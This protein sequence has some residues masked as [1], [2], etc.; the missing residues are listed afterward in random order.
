MRVRKLVIV[1]LVVLALAVGAAL[2]LRALLD[3]QMLARTIESQAAAWLER[4]VHIG[5]ARA[6][7][8]PTPRI[9]LTTVAVDGPPALVADEVIVGAGLKALFQRRVEDAVVRV[10]NGTITLDASAPTRPSPAS[11]ASGPSTPTT[12]SDAAGSRGGG[13]TIASVGEIRFENVAVRGGGRTLLLDFEGSL[14][15]DALDVRRLS[16]SSGETSIE[17]K[18]TVTSLQKLDGTFDLT[19][20][21]VDVDDVLALL[22]ALAPQSPSS[23]RA[24]TPGAGDTKG[25]GF[26]HILARAS[27]DKARALGYQIDHLTTSIDLHGTTL[28]ANPL[29]FELYGGRYDSKLALDLAAHRT[30]LDHNATLTGANVATLARLLGHPG[31]A[32]G[33]LNMTMHVRGAGTDLA[34]AAHAAQGAANVNLLNG[35]LEGLDVVRQ[36]F[37]VLGTAAPPNVGK[38]FDS[39]SAKLALAG[40]AM[41]ADEVLM[42]APDFD[43]RGHAR[44]ASTNALSGQA[45]VTLS[46]ALSKQAQGRNK[47]LKLMFE[48]GR[49]ALPVSLS[50]TLLQPIVTPDMGNLLARAAQNKMKAEINKATNKAGSDLL[51]KLFKKP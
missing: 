40:G 47:D 17:G 31:M 15:G 21:L 42:H 14:S 16:A 36:T 12:A 5:A 32:S 24:A 34:A 49:I 22:A 11:P 29:R 44:V 43:L 33:S 28:A 48:E 3:P 45:Q 19:S 7:I 20:K 23:G 10:H 35:T 8:F 9:T 25:F 41:T 51:N 18:G 13:F 50:G 46:D 4:P 1:A 26:G 38:R 37:V 39:L 27:I 6:H 2:A 30:V